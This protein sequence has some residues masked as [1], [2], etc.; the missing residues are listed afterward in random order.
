MVV[1]I[2]AG[3][4]ALSAKQLLND[5][6]PIALLMSLGRSLGFLLVQDLPR[7]ADQ[8]TSLLGGLFETLKKL[9]GGASDG[10]G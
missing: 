9:H 1:A 4:Q 7:M 10:S 2:R 6:R 5:A 3:T 8:A